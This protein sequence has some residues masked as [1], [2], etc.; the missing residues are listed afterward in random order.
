MGV[1]DV[2]KFKEVNDEYGHEAGDEILMQ[3][4]RLA[5]QSCR[6]S[7]VVGRYGG[8][9][10]LFVLPEASLVAAVEFADRFRQ[11]VEEKPFRLSQGETLNLNV[12]LGVSQTAGTASASNLI[13]S[14]DAALYQAKSAGG[15][16][17]CCEEAA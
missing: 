8:D 4:A 13:A 16:R 10:F 12:S 3:L 5:R 7:D 1:L 11:K 2:D 14:A 6:K 15:N 9:E 17:V